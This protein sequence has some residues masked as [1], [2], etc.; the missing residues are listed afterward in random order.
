MGV[1]DSNFP[2]IEGGTLSMTVAS[3][4]ALRGAV[5]A[6]VVALSISS[7]TRGQTVINIPPSNPITSAGAGVTVNVLPGGQLTSTF[8]TQA[9]GTLNVNGGSTGI[10]ISQSGGVVNLLDG[11]IN[12]LSVDS[13]SSVT[14]TGGLVA[15]QIYSYSAVQM[16]GGRVG[17]VYMSPTAG[18]AAVITG[19][20]I[21]NLRGSTGAS[22]E[23]VGV[24]FEIDGVPVS[25]LNNVGDSVQVNL[26]TNSNLSLSS[27]LT[28][29][30]ADGRAFGHN[31]WSNVI[32]NGV[33]TLRRSAAPTAPTAG[34]IHVTT[35]SALEWVGAGQNVIV[36]SGGQLPEHF[37][38]GPGSRIQIDGGRVE[39][40]MHAVG[41]AVTINSGS[42]GYRFDAYE[43]TVVDLNGGTMNGSAQFFHGSTLN[44]HGGVLGGATLGSGATAN[45]YGGD[46]Y[47]FNVGLG[48]VANVFAGEN[49]RMSSSGASNVYGGNFSNVSMSGPTLLA[50]GAFPG[51]LDMGN[52]TLTLEGTEFRR[53]GVLV[54]GL[55][56]VGD[57]ATLNNIQ[58]WDVIHGVLRDGTSFVLT[59]RTLAQ[60]PNSIKLVQSAPTTGPTTISV[61]NDPAPLGIRSGQSLTLSAGGK[62]AENFTAGWGSSLTITDGQVE[63]N[64]KAI[65]ANIQMTGGSLGS[66]HLFATQMSIAGAASWGDL[67][68]FPSSTVNIG[69]DASSSGGTVR[70]YEGAQL[71][72]SGGGVGA[73]ESYAGSVVNVSGGTLQGGIANGSQISVS[74]GEVHGMSLYSQSE[75]NA[76]GGWIEHVNLQEGSSAL[77]AGASVERLMV[78]TGTEARIDSGNVG[79]LFTTGSVELRGGALGDN[80]EWGGVMDVYGSD[81]QVDGV[82]VAGLGAPGDS[83][84]FQYAA[85]SMFTGTLSDGTPFAITT[86]DNSAIVSTG[87]AVRLV[88]T[89]P[90]SLPP[91][92]DVPTQPAPYGARA[93]QTVIVRDGGAL[94]ANFV[95]GHDSVVTIEGGDV[96]DNFEAERSQVTMSGG[97][98]GQRM[99]VFGG[100]VMTVSGGDIGTEW[101]VMPGGRLDVSGGTLQN[102]GRIY[103]GTLNVSGGSIGHSLEA[104]DGAVVNI[105]GGTISSEFEVYSGSHVNVSGGDVGSNFHLESGVSANITGGR[106]REFEPRAGSSVSISGGQIDSISPR[107]GS[108][109][110]IHDGAFADSFDNATGATTKLFGV[111][112][113]VN[114]TAVP[115]L[116]AVGSEV[117]LTLATNQLLT[118]TFEGGTPLS[119]LSSEGEALRTVRLVQSAPPA[120]GPANISVSNASALTGARGGQTVTV[121][122]GGSLGANFH[123]GRGSTINLD[124]GSIGANLE[125]YHATVN[126]ASGQV[127]NNLDAFAGSQI[128]VQGGQVGLGLDAYAQS[129]VNLSGGT[130]STVNA[131]SGSAINVSGGKLSSLAASSGSTT[132]WNGGVLPGMSVSSGA[133]LTIRGFNF[134][135]NGVP[136]AGLGNVGDMLPLDV[137]SG[138]LLTGVLEDGTAVVLNRR[139]QTGPTIANGTLKLMRSA[140]TGNLAPSYQ[141]VASSTA[142]FA[143]GAGQTLELQPQGTLA[144]DFIAGPQSVVSMLGGSMGTRFTALDA[145]VL[146]RGGNVGAQFTALKGTEVE[147]LGGTIASGFSIYGG[148]HASIYGGSFQQTGFAFLSGSTV[149]LYGSNFKLNGQTIAGL[150]AIGNMVTVTERGTQFVLTGTLANGTALNIRLLLAADHGGIAPFSGIS[151]DATLRLRRLDQAPLPGDFDG[152]GIVDGADLLSWQRTGSSAVGLA[153]WRGSMG[154]ANAGAASGSVPEPGGVSLAIATLGCVFVVRRRRKAA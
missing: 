53:N 106:L 27:V 99:D 76:T 35:T 131:R 92:I 26:P 147:V 62:L 91:V 52:A 3:R 133:S 38:A 17:T 36:E 15:D 73:L 126:I 144:P 63:G 80:Q 119:F 5:F 105:S 130:I 149:D 90:T 127:G 68:I 51:W 4:V 12:A 148:A 69:P 56:N 67:N 9:G 138:G 42:L 18:S 70:V 98:V 77:V 2:D 109:V 75:I 11:T 28:G 47:N 37:R 24:D 95:A 19:G 84:L 29:T 124:G 14:V 57:M 88:L 34:D 46:I 143:I 59:E 93:G 72:V 81:F 125:A 136:L 20:A 102:Q 71:N 1:C 31:Q 100:A 108:M 118:G 6:L 150:D 120:V 78:W 48:G 152:N 13:G 128:N 137:A 123:A 79:A 40:A 111:D 122:S 30:L 33:L 16:S 115:G 129:T 140:N 87:A 141:A 139:S 146:I 83:A 110:N 97:T 7:R 55:G 112:F 89:P 104:R 41:A 96:G 43:G 60:L 86:N 23:L 22:I 153:K 107:S 39:D 54:S 142:P 116:G 85:G 82:P 134:E 64:L 101:A 132:V 117:T 32:Q 61:P 65:G 58:P 151:S 154:L 113:E 49:L 103:G 50:G 8:T 114:G 74:G 45:I 66:A 121:A 94:G 10:V 135:L 21:E 44:V 25:G 145:D